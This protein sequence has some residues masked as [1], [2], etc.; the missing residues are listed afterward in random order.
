MSQHDT[1]TQALEQIAMAAEATVCNPAWIAQHA[2]AALAKAQ[3]QA[4]QAHALDRGAIIDL[5]SPLSRNT[6]DHDIDFAFRVLDAAQAKQ[7]AGEV[8]A[9]LHDDGYWTPAKSEA[10]R[11]LN[12][13]LMRAG[14]RVEVCL[15]TAATPP[16][17]PAPV[18]P[19]GWRM[20]PVEPTP[21]MKSA[22]ITI[23]IYSEVSDSIGALTWA[24]VAA[25]YRA[26]LT[27]SPTPPA[28]A[29]QQGGE[30]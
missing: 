21:E 27:A 12:E 8:V 9:T 5:I 1:L 2:R 15:P 11:A 16:A 19:E 26:M 10:G 29:A 23:E 17:Q 28:Q 13:R 24:E 7:V 4:P 18:V 30:A 22:G 20:V 25:I 3:A 14:T 6:A